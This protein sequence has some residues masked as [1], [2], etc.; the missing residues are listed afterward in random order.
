[1][2]SSCFQWTVNEEASSPALH[3]LREGVQALPTSQ[4]W[5]ATQVFGRYPAPPLCS[6]CHFA[7]PT[8]SQPRSAVSIRCTREF[9]PTKPISSISIPPRSSSLPV[10][11]YLYIK[12]LSLF[13]PSAAIP[14]GL[15]RL[16]TPISGTTFFHNNSLLEI[17]ANLQRTHTDFCV[18]ESLYRS[19]LPCYTV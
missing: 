6:F 12:G 5:H 19:T 14:W 16:S 9:F 7:S 1:M 11:Y 10:W 13:C 15:D 2:S 3:V 4:A 17:W 18:L 8:Q